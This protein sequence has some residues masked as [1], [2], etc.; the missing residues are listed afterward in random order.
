MKRIVMIMGILFSYQAVAATTTVT[1]TGNLDSGLNKIELELRSM[2]EGSTVIITADDSD[3]PTI[4]LEACGSNDYNDP[5]QNSWVVTCDVTKLAQDTATAIEFAVYQLYVSTETNTIA[6]YF[7]T[8]N[9]GQGN[10][11]AGYYLG[12]ELVCVKSIAN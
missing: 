7:T 2:L 10:T 12:Q 3:A 6:D 5:A 8:F 4:I 1:C 9:K 11:S